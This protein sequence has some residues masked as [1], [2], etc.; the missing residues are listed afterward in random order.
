[1]W[2]KSGPGGHI[3]LAAQGVPNASKRGTKSKVTHKWAGWLHNPYL[4]PGAQRFRPGW[5]TQRLTRGGR[6]SSD[7]HVGPFA[8]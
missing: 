4:T 1:M 5:L 3:T 7:P 8:T 2:P 6:I